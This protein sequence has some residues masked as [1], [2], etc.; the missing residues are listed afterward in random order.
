MGWNST[1]DPLA[2]VGYSHLTF[3]SRAAAERF[4][5]EQ[6]W[7]F[8]VAKD[9]NEHSRLK[10]HTRWVDY[11]SVYSTKRAGIPLDPAQY[12]DPSA[13]YRGCKGKFTAKGS[14]ELAKE[15]MLVDGVAGKKK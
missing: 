5:K 15:G 3:D 13:G 11:G 7:S 6:G 2:N 8:V 14:Y 10:R 12:S 4:A 9:P 1:A